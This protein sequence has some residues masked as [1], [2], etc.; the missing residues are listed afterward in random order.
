VL[1]DYV[2]SPKRDIYAVFQPNRF[3]STRQRLFVDH[4]VSTCK[5]LP[6]ES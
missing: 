3:Q 1:S 6:W 4:L 5:Q 2:T